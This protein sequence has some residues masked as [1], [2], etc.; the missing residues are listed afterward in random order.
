MD[1]QPDV[2]EA[3]EVAQRAVDARVE[4]DG[5]VD[6]WTPEVTPYLDD[7]RPRGVLA[8]RSPRHPNPIGLALVELVAVEPGVLRIRGAD[9]LDGTPVIDVKPYVPLFDARDPAEVRTGWFAAAAE[10][11]RTVRSD[12]RYGA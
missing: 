5:R 12:R 1:E 10:R 3:V 2:R 4:L 6:G 7:S 11:V 9:L 8:T